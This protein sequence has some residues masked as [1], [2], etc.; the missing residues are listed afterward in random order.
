MAYK[1]FRVKQTFITHA[2]KLYFNV[3]IFSLEM[4]F[5]L[6]ISPFCLFLSFLM[7]IRESITN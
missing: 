5:I 2:V 6:R 7:D 3:A 1:E 4:Y